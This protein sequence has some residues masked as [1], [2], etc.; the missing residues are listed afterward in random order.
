MSGGDTMSKIF[1]V[2]D[3]TNIRELVEYTLKSS[4]FFVQGF[5][6]AE[7][8]FDK[9]K[10]EKP[11]LILLDVMLPDKDGISILKELRNSNE[12]K[13]IPVIMLTAKSGQLD[14]IKGLDYGADDYITKPFDIIELISRIKAVLRRTKPEGE[15][16]THREISLNKKRH[17]IL[18]NG[19][20]VS[21]TFKEFELLYHLLLNQGMVLGRDQ[22]MNLVWGT[23]FEGETRTV[24]VHIRT[25]RQKLGTYGDYIKTVRNVGYK[26]DKE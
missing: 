11:D 19:E 18:V 21:L 17:T 12:Y 14:K 15:N 26:I 16:I 4:G 9:I 5:E 8:F 3:D 24:D 23:D 1:Y 7:S 13:N 20:N 22:L 25:L 2:E 10:T 6:F